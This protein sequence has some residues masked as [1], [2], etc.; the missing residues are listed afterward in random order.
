MH[1]CLAHNLQIEERTIDVHRLK[2]REAI[3]KAE[4]AIRDALAAGDTR[5]RVICGSGNH[6]LGKIPSLKLALVAAM[7]QH[8][9]ETEVDPYNPGV[10]NIKLPIS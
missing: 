10:L 5:L 9:I 7:E 4:I 2:T 1:V 6:S 8:R 3:R